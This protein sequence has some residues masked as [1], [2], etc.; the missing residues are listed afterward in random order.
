[1]DKELIKEQ[2]L[3]LDPTKKSVNFHK[4]MGHC[5]LSCAKECCNIRESIQVCADYCSTDV[6][7][8]DH[9][10]FQIYLELVQSKEQN[11]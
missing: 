4:A 8:M 9:D 1:M 7:Q 5:C 2:L 11:L 3:K 6:E 10:Q